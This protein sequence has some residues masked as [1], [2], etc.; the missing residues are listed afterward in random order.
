M[1][2]KEGV[3][4]RKEENKVQILWCSAWSQQQCVQCHCTKA[5]SMAKDHLIVS[6]IRGSETGLHCEILSVFSGD[7]G[8]CT[9][10]HTADRRR[11]GLLHGSLC[12][13]SVRCHVKSLSRIQST[14][15]GVPQCEHACGA[16]LCSPWWIL[17]RTPSTCMAFPPCG[18]ACVSAALRQKWK[19]CHSRSTGTVSLLCESLRVRSSFLTRR[20]ASRSR[21][22]ERASRLYDCACEGS[23]H[24]CSW[25]LCRS[26][27]K[28]V[29]SAVC[30]AAGEQS[31]TQ[32]SW[33][34]SRTAGTDWTAE[35]DGSF[36]V[37][38]ARLYPGIP[39]RTVCMWK[40]GS[41]CESACA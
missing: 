11:A 3:S 9:F 4:K 7:W 39:P 24:A 5:S 16:S 8:T 35:E 21:C 6:R 36:D 12:V 13:F 37:I 22:T 38:L 15:R 23:D 30:G 1:E 17:S 25:R 33:K 28:S 26:V 20:N 27:C 34:T 14:R 32:P 40:C 10:L 18:C 31:N 2:D 41:G 19:P 29:S